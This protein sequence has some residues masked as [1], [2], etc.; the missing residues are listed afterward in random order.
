MSMVIKTIFDY[1]LIHE[2]EAG[3]DAKVFLV[4]KTDHHYVIKRYQITDD[5]I[6]ECSLLRE[7]SVLKKIIH[8]HIIK[9]IEIIKDES[10]IYLVLEYGGETL[11]NFVINNIKNKKQINTELVTLQMIEAMNYLHENGYIHCDIN[12][13][14]ILCCDNTIKIIDFCRSTRKYRND[15]IFLPSL[16][17]QP[18]ELL[19]QKPIVDSTKLDIWMMGCIIYFI[20]TGKLLFIGEDQ[21]EFIKNIEH[22][23]KDENIKSFKGIKNFINGSLKKMFSLN[24][25]K[26]ISTKEILGLCV[27][28]YK[29]YSIKINDINLFEVIYKYIDKTKIK[30]TYSSNI[31]SDINIY[32]HLSSKINFSIETIFITIKNVNKLIEEKQILEYK[33]IC[34]WL[35]NKIVGQI[36]LTYYSLQN[37]YEHFNILFDLTTVKTKIFEVCMDLDWDVDPYTLYDFHIFVSHFKQKFILLSLLLCEH[38]SKDVYKL[39]FIFEKLGIKNN[40]IKLYEKIYEKLKKYYT[41]VIN[42]YKKDM[43]LFNNLVDSETINWILEMK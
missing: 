20:I 18:Y 28:K 39:K 7:L 25:C 15:I 10:Y 37:F 5:T 38:K 33:I 13:K 34:F 8:P 19:V 9:L 41:C 17:F 21:R 24:P 22:N 16:Y 29:Q 12:F 40:K 11:L 2:L 43:T 36:D 3:Y 32:K 23:I 4:K 27:D 1:V 14:N 26:R 30:N 35:A 6:V 42:M 31:I